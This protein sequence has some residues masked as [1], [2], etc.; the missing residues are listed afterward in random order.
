MLTLHA[1]ALRFSKTTPPAVPIPDTANLPI[2]SDNVIPS[3]LVHLGV[4]DLSDSDPA[5]GLAPLFPSARD[6][7]VLEP[8]LAAAPPPPAPAVASIKPKKPPPKE[9]PLLTVAQAFVLRAA[10]IDACELLV[11]YGKTLDEAQ[12]ELAWLKELTPPEVDAWLW[13]VAKDRPD[14]RQLERFALRNTAYF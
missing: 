10:A 4:L 3:L 1:V 11:E 13:A 12:G 6:P 2:F 8:L 9:G 14:Y 7:A 5:L